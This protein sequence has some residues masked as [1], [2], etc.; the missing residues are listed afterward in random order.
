V[1]QF[2][3]LVV[4]A[5][6]LRSAAET[7]APQTDPLPEFGVDR[8]LFRS[9]FFR[10]AGLARLSETAY[11]I[12]GRIVRALC[13]RAVLE[14]HV[15]IASIPVV[16]IGLVG[17]GAKMFPNRHH[18]AT[19][20]PVHYPSHS[21]IHQLTTTTTT[22]FPTK[23]LRAS[24]ASWKSGWGK[25]MRPEN[26]NCAQGRKFD[27]VWFVGG[28]RPFLLRHSRRTDPRRNGWHD[29]FQP[30]ERHGG[31]HAGVTVPIIVHSSRRNLVLSPLPSRYNRPESN[32]QIGMAS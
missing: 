20:Y 31:F 1:G 10:P 28:E 2:G 16:R 8:N 25:E 19:H 11:T 24:G 6:R 7:A 22:T 13:V 3:W 21:P 4:R 29:R 32:L 30:R 18:H 12:Q 14:E 15:V 26:D 23:F 27:L 5:S 9:L 17:G